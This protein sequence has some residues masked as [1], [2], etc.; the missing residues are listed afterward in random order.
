MKNNKML[1]VELLMYL[2]TL[3]KPP[4]ELALH[5]ASSSPAVYENVAGFLGEVLPWMNLDP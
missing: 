1:F 2:A 4:S 3:H 5:M